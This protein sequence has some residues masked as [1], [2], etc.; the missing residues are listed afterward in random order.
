MT[1]GRDGRSPR[2]LCISPAFV[3]QANAEAFCAAKMVMALTAEGVDVTVLQDE[4]YV[5]QGTFGRDPSAMWQE[6]LGTVA[7][8]GPVSHGPLQAFWHLVRYRAYTRWT[9]AAVGRAREL[10]AGKPFDLVY[11]RSL[12]PQAH[13]AGFWCARELHLP[14]VANINDPWD[15]HLFPGGAK[16]KVSWTRAR[17]SRYWLRKTLREADLVTYP[18]RRLAAFTCRLAGI[19]RAGEVIPHVGLSLP[20][21]DRQTR[22]HLVHAGKLGVRELTGGR[23]SRGLLTG[24]ARFLEQRPEARGLTRLTF[25]G[26]ED[27]ET[28]SL[29]IELGLQ[30]TVACTGQTSYEESLRWIASASVCVLVET[31]MSEG[32]YLPSKVADYVAAGKPVLALSP[33]V[34]TIADMLPD[35]G[36]VRVG[37]EDTGA[38]AEAITDLFEA[39]RQGALDTRKPSEK[40]VRTFRAEAVAGAFLAHVRRLT[41]A[42]GKLRK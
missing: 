27:P 7:G 5:I 40:L 42:P 29:I 21:D 11:S 18:C 4:R 16:E 12:P 41:S 15:V 22:F 32:I 14:W 33:A 6:P 28:C 34:G 13:V 10:H 17:L 19:E 23:S 35:A 3:P 38:V 1:D 25:V 31:D 39:Y 36:L 8:M 26:F 24:L 20:A 9:D 2:I 30:G 37:V